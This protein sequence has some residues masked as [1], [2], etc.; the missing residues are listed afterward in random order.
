MAHMEW[1]WMVSGEQW[2]WEW[3]GNSKNVSCGVNN[4]HQWWMQYIRRLNVQK[5]QDER[6]EREREERKKREKVRVTRATT[7]TRATWH[8][9]PPMEASAADCM[10]IVSCCRR[11]RDEREGERERETCRRAAAKNCYR[12]KYT[13]QRA[14]DR[15]DL[16][17][18]LRF[19]GHKSSRALFLLSPLHFLLCVVHLSLS[20]SP[21]IH[22]LSRMASVLVILSCDFSSSWLP[23]FVSVLLP[24]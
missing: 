18:L 19:K 3:E 5:L 23:L 8:S 10:W 9:S 22:G 20:L 14:K 12:I 21:L 4:R 13:P 6:G 7:T 16:Y 1:T 2:G 17:F 11:W 24:N 15:A